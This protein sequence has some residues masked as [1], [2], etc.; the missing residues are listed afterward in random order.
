MFFGLAVGL[1]YG[2]VPG[3]IQKRTAPNEGIHRSARRALAIGLFFGLFF[4][5][6]FGLFFGPAKALLFEL[7]FGLAG[8][9]V[10]GGHACLQHLA[11]RVLLVMH[12]FAPLQYI[13]FL[14]NATERMLLRRVGGG[15]IFIHRLLLEHFAAYPRTTG[16]QQAA[17]TDDWAVDPR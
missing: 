4:A 7:F 10:F 1:I 8:G 13:R 6:P 14:D 2:L 12:G 11:V 15:Y 17:R 3:L 16:I 9:L 5:L